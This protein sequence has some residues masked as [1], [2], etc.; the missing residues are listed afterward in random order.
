MLSSF[1][2][3]LM[4]ANFSTVS[5]YSK[6]LREIGHENLGFYSLAIL[7]TTSAFSNLVIP[8]IV[9]TTVNKRML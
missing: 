3:I 8:Y 6:V 2:F 7:Y 5:I 4:F 1:F 9:N